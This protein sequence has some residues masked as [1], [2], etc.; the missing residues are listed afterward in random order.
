[1][2][3]ACSPPRAPEYSMAISGNAFLN[4]SVMALRMSSPGGPHTTTFPSF[5]AAL[6]TFSH[7][8]FQSDGF[9]AGTVALK[10]TKRKPDKETVNVRRSNTP[11]LLSCFSGFNP[12]SRWMRLSQSNFDN[13]LV[14]L[15][16]SY[17][18]TI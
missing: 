1:M 10:P 5:F 6:I 17:E 3:V 2:R 11:H 4:P 9:A 15:R 12:P 7:R 16:Y 18:V 13:R 14:G 8:S